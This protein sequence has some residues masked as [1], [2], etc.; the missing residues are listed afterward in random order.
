MCPSGD[1]VHRY[2]PPFRAVES[3]TRID[4]HKPSLNES[5]CVRL[6]SSLLTKLITTYLNTMMDHAVRDKGDKRRSQPGLERWPNKVHNAL[7]LM[8]D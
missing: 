7:L 1:L 2:T 3:F 5:I 6:A 4:F 8:T